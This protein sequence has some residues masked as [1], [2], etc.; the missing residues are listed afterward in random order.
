MRQRSG[1]TFRAV[2]T[3]VLITGISFGARK[4]FAADTAFGCLFHPPD[5]LGACS[6]QQACDDLCQN[7]YGGIQGNCVQGCCF[8][9][10]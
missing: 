7:T 9:E 1:R 8:C 5:E 2:I 10:F 4:A 6:S 3:L